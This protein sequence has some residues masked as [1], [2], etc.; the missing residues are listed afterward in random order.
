MCYHR[1]ITC[2][3]CLYLF[4]TAGP[5]CLF[6]YSR[7]FGEISALATAVARE[8]PGSAQV[9]N[10]WNT[11]EVFLCVQ[12]GPS[13]PESLLVFRASEL[14]PGCSHELLQ[15]LFSWR[16]QTSARNSRTEPVPSPLSFWSCLITFPPLGPC[17]SMLREG[18]S[19][20]GL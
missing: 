12:C 18:A 17:H 8:A 20:C 4:S 1:D 2:G 15:K 14:P 19:V 10:L 3:V 16:C 7:L 5:F 9:C 11:G 6:Y 13:R